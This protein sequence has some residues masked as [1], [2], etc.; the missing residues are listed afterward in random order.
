MPS[1]YSHIAA[2]SMA[3]LSEIIKLEPE[4][5]SWCAGYAPSQG[6]RCHAPTNARGRSSAMML[7]NEG[8]KDLRAGRNINTLLESLA[9][10]VLCTRFHQNQASDLACRWKRQVRTYLDSQVVSTPYPRP[11]RTSSRMGSETAEANTEERI[12]VLRQRLRDAEEEIR[13]LEIAQSSLPVTTNPPRREAE[14]LSA[15]VN[16]RSRANAPSENPLINRVNETLRRD[17]TQSSTNQSAITVPRPVQAPTSRQ[18]S[19]IPISRPRPVNTP[20]EARV[21][22]RIDTTASQDETPQPIRREIEGECGICLCGLQSSQDEDWGEEEESENSGGSDH[23]DNDHDNDNEEDDYDD[24]DADENLEE[25]VWCKARCGVNFH[26][27]CI[28]QWLQTSHAPTCP[29][30]RS[31]WKH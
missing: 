30:C 17:S 16:S 22:S 23:S 5:E 15:V 21:F 7:L 20:T 4:K 11:V 25:L 27:Q 28:D 9:P 2:S 14:D 6:R 12:A 1:Q 26:K 3:S 13:H 18:T 10:H 19:A 8:T 29:T 31:D 24:T